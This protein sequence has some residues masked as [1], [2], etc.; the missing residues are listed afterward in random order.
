MLVFLWSALLRS[1]LA[2]TFS[3]AFML[4]SLSLL[5]TFKNIAITQNVYHNS[6]PRKPS[7]NEGAPI[8]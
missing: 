7:Q 2:S 4:N 5:S 8:Y 3:L 1:Y 6:E